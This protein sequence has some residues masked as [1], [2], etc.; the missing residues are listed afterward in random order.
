MISAVSPAPKR[1]IIIR[2]LVRGFQDDLCAYMDAMAASFEYN[3][4][5]GIPTPG[6][7]CL[8]EPVLP[9]ITITDTAADDATQLYDDDDETTIDSPLEPSP[10]SS[11]NVSPVVSPSQRGQSR[12]RPADYYGRR[13]HAEVPQGQNLYCPYS[14][15]AGVVT[16]FITTPDGTLCSGTILR[17]P[18]TSRASNGYINNNGS[19]IPFTARLVS[20]KDKRM[21]ICIP[22]EYG[23]YVVTIGIHSD[24]Q[25]RRMMPVD[26]PHRKFMGQKYENLI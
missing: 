8:P 7:H 23:P 13:Y 26:G 16:V 10:A 20:R 17:K 22:C 2:P 19:L 25:A 12:K 14:V 4:M 15:P 1:K 6:V 24:G 5:T 11:A 3:N 18:S 21:I 9:S